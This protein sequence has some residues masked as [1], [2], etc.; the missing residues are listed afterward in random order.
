MVPTDVTTSTSP[1]YK[2]VGQTLL[3]FGTAGTDDVSSLVPA[4]TGSINVI[5]LTG[6]YTLTPTQVVGPPSLY[7]T[8]QSKG[9]ATYVSGYPEY[10]TTGERL[11]GSITAA[12]DHLYFATTSGT[13]NGIDSRGSLGGSTYSID[14]TAAL[15]S[16]NALLT[17]TNSAGGTA[18]TVLVAPAASGGQESS[19]SPTRTSTSRA[20]DAQPERAGRQRRGTDTVRLPGVV[21]PEHR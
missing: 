20:A 4:V 17:L 6:N 11:Y 15:N 5:P 8:A 13:V 18:G 21:L 2:Y 16:S 14:L 12:G 10:V 1:F 3:A 19:R 9:V 7:T